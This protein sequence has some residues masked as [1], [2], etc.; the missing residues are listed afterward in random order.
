MNDNDESYLHN[1]DSRTGVYPPMEF[2]G[3]WIEHWPNGQLKFR[4]HFDRRNMR[5]GQHIS[6]WE[7]GVLQEL[8]FWNEGFACGTITWF[9]EDGSKEVERDFGEYGG[10]TRSWIER[11][12][13]VSG[14]LSYLCLWKEDVLVAEWTRPDLRELE[15]EIDLDGIVKEAVRMVYPD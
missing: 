8:S 5:I 9:R 14:P 1:P 6:F 2:E 3:L 11:F 4:G 15:K 7:N 12:F 13:S 10:R